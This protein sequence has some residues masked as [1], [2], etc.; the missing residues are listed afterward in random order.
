M[1]RD[2][3]ALG[4][5]E[6]EELREDGPARCRPC[7]LRDG[8][9][10]PLHYGCALD[11]QAVVTRRIQQRR[12]PS[13]TCTLSR[14]LEGEEEGVGVAKKGGR[15]IIVGIALQF[16]QKT[17]GLAW[18]AR[19][20]PLPRIPNYSP[21]Q[22]SRHVLHATLVTNLVPSFSQQISNQISTNPRT[23]LERPG[24]HLLPSSA[25]TAPPRRPLRTTPI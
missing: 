17:P 12:E 13:R 20:N 11:D 19:K 4:G 7:A 15:V 21:C 10:G 6:G 1:G 14:N 22:I 18:L 23:T 8:G 9:L 5:A 24:N 3:I 25:S 2:G 16:V